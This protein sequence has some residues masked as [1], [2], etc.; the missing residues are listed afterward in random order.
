DPGAGDVAER[1]HLQPEDQDA[2]DLKR[3]EADRCP[4]DRPRW[5]VD[6]VQKSVVVDPVDAGAF[7][8][9]ATG[10]PIIGGVMERPAAEGEDSHNHPGAEERGGESHEWSCPGE[11][12]RYPF[13]GGASRPGPD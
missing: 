10:E 13:D 9:M 8:D 4:D 5:S 12:A 3:E 2:D 7:E 11:A 1:E 6:E